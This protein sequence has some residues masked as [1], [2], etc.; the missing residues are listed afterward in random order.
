MNGLC[1]RVRSSFNN[2]SRVFRRQEWHARPGGV[3]SPGRQ[4]QVPHAGRFREG[5][6]KDSAGRGTQSLLSLHQLSQAGHCK[7]TV[8]F[9]FFLLF[10]FCRG[11]TGQLSLR[12]AATFVKE[13]SISL[14]VSVVGL[15]VSTFPPLPFYHITIDQYFYLIQDCEILFSYILHLLWCYTRFCLVPIVSFRMLLD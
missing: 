4:W 8:A 6:R 5:G 3:G 15:F 1:L 10:A 11:E 7:F 2:M 9:L 13:N 12:C 14:L